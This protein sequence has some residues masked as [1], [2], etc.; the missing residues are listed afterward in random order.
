MFILNETGNCLGFSVSDSL[1]LV[2]AGLAYS[3]T[4]RTLLEV[5]PIR[6]AGLKKEAAVTIDSRIVAWG[7]VVSWCQRMLLSASGLC[8]SCLLCSR[9][10][11]TDVDQ[12]MVKIGNGGLLIGS[13]VRRW[14]LVRSKLSLFPSEVMFETWWFLWFDSQGEGHVAGG[15]CITDSRRSGVSEGASSGSFF[16][17]WES[18]IFML[19]LS[20]LCFEIYIYAGFVLWSL[21]LRFWVFMFKRSS[22]VGICI[23][24]VNSSMFMVKPVWGFSVADVSRWCFKP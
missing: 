7:W 22:C 16:R 3:E 17:T 24:T 8:F 20:E 15:I 4:S 13:V 10:D 5:V 11:R 9:E 14:S 19:G 2:G 18:S 12:S 23:L 1:G 21:H 6:V